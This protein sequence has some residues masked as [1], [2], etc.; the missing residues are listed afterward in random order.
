MGY[1]IEDVSGNSTGGPD[2]FTFTLDLT[3]PGASTVTGDFDEVPLFGGG[4][5]GEAP[6]GYV[7]SAL[8]NPALG[9]LAA[10][11][12]TGQFTFTVDRA[13][14]MATGSAQTVSFTVTGYGSGGNIDTDTVF[15]N[16][17]ICVARGTLVDT[18]SGPRPVE[19]LSTGDAVLTADGRAERILWI[20]SRRLGSEE[21]ARAPELRPVQIAAGALGDGLPRRSLL[22]SPQH[23]VL[24]DGWLAELV[25]GQDG[26]LVPAHRLADGRRIRRVLPQ[27]GVE[28]FHVLLD[29]H[30]IILTEGL[31][32]ESFYPGAYALAG[33]TTKARTSL[34]HAVPGLAFDPESYGPPA[35]AVA[36]RD[37]ARVIAARL[38]A[39]RAKRERIAA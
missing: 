36:S 24:I 29:R 35:C 28:Y 34:F 9:T 8:S 27:E 17:L 16:I 10:D 31:P 23:H 1:N 32:T 5:G 21:L 25:T 2:Q 38:G 20:G 30:E 13:A 14:V 22:V 26:V 3:V 18:P 15:I 33:L 19:T 6:G 37:E 11:G 39:G 12:T 4:G 7:F